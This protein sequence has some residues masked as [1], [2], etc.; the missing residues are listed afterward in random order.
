MFFQKL[1][2]ARNF[3]KHADR[4]PTACIEFSQFEAEVVLV[5]AC[6]THK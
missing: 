2:S 6:L 3:F 5:D 1:D 4:N